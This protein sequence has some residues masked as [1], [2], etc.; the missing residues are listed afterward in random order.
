MED[1]RSISETCKRRFFYTC[2]CVNVWTVEGWI[3]WRNVR[4]AVKQSGVYSSRVSACNPR[5]INRT[6]KEGNAWP[7]VYPTFIRI[8]VGESQTNVQTVRCV[9]Q[10]GVLCAVLS[11]QCWFIGVVIQ[12]ND[13]YLWIKDGG[14]S[15]TC[16][17]LVVISLYE[18]PA[19][20]SRRK[21]TLGTFEVNQICT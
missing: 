17:T 18:R 15:K 6:F 3:P 2:S 16:T 10:V 13:W 14:W 9:W 8:Q 11:C 20:D 5:G 21:F 1:A 19:N 7:A 12:L 4:P